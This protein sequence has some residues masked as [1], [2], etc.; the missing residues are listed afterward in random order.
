MSSVASGYGDLNEVKRRLNQTQ[1]TDSSDTK[2]QEM[3]N[4]SDNY[5]NT[6][7][8]VHAVTPI[9]NPDAELISLS[10]SLAATLFNYWQTPTKDRNLDSIKEWKKS[11]T[12]HIMAAYGRKSAGQLG[13]QELFGKTSGF[14]P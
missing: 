13:G 7:I 3:I 5:V 9:S 4:E 8:G 12:E 1:L 2:I 10:S 14:A 6:Q 11:I